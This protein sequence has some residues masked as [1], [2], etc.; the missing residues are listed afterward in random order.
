MRTREPA[1]LARS[2][3]PS[4]RCA[5]AARRRPAPTVFSAAMRCGDRLG[6]FA[7]VVGEVQALGPARAGSA[8]GGRLAVADEQHR[9]ARGTGRRL[10]PWPTTLP[11]G[12]AANASRVRSSGTGMMRRVHRPDSLD[13][14]ER[15]TIVDCRACPRLVAWREPVGARS[16]R[17]TRDE[18]YWG[19]PVPAASVTPHAPCSSSGWRRPRTARNRTGRVFTGDRSGDLLFRALHRAGFANQP[20]SA[21]RDDG[22]AAHRRLHH[23]AASVRPAGQQADARRAR[24][25]PAVPRRELAAAP[26]VRVFVVLGAFAYEVLAGGSGSGPAPLRPRRRSRTASRRPRRSRSCARTTRA[27]R[28]PSPGGSP[29]ML[30]AVFARVRSRSKSAGRDA[31]H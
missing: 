21:S 7:A 31:D 26:D 16:G 29:A 6:L 28:T 22:L 19:R 24:P 9:V 14:A 8:G 30:D 17:R 4:P 11:C 25:L 18:D 23:R 10:R 13:A 12:S 1:G 27:S 20:T 2:A 3:P 15:R 5:P